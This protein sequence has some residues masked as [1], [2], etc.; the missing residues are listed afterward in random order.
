MNAVNT[1]AQHKAGSQDSPSAFM[2]DTLASGQG[3][4]RE[5]LVSVV[6]DKSAEAVEF[7]KREGGVDL[8]LLTQCGG[9]SYPRTH[10]TVSATAGKPTNV[11]FDIVTAL[12]KRIE[13]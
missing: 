11:G 3:V 8:S 4:C 9:H 2:A 10:R 1:P 12:I 6:I 7:L 13:D 5:P